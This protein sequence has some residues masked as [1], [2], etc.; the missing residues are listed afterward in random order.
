MTWDL[1]RAATTACAQWATFFLDGEMFAIAVDEVQ[2]VLLPQPLTPVPHA[3]PQMLGLLNLRGQIMPAIDLRHRLGIPARPAD[4]SAGNQV[5][6]TTLDGPL[7]LLVDEVGD[8]HE[9]AGADW[10]ATPETV[11]AADRRFVFGVCALKGGLVRGLSA[12]QLGF[13]DEP[14]A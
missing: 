7:S 4:V 3:P 2:E 13:D 6:V 11:R 10:R 9:L 1:H 12:V 14:D 8:V 5:V